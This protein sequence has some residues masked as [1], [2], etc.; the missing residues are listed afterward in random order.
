MTWNDFRSYRAIAVVIV[1]LAISHGPEYIC[2][3]C[4]S[5]NNSDFKGFIQVRKADA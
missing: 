2:N 3:R 4:V 1:A 5:R